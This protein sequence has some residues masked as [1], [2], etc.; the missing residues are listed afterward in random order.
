MREPVRT[1]WSVHHRRGREGRR[2]DNGFANL[3]VVCGSSNVDGCHG[4]I[5]SRRSEARPNGWWL[6][7][8]TAEH[9]A[10][11]PVLVDHG[12]R[13]VHLTDNGQYS[14]DPPPAGVA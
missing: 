9:P 10:T 1:N 12:S 5:H 3:L 6:S 2:T 4:R 14:D 7:R 8:Q 13:W 11:V